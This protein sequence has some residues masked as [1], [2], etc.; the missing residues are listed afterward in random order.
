MRGE[1][2]SGKSGEVEAPSSTK[3]L[4]AKAYQIIRGELTTGVFA[5]G[6]KLLLQALAD[7]LGMSLTPVREALMRLAAERILEIGSDRSIFVPTIDRDRLREIRDLRLLLEGIAIAKATERLTPDL[8]DETERTMRDL[9][10]AKAMNDLPK[11]FTLRHRFHFQLYAEANAPVLLQ[12]IESLWLQA[13]PLLHQAYH[14]HMASAREGGTLI[15]AL[16]RRD[17]R[18]AEVAL[19]SLILDTFERIEADFDSPPNEV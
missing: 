15:N 17:P 11:A 10:A 5:P 16:R 7:R 19:R 14:W 12:H 13:G 18:G 3:T 9:H 4:G 8:I 6:E 2:D 1:G